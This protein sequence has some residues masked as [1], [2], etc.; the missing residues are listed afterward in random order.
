GNPIGNPV[1]LDGEGKGTL[2]VPPSESGKQLD[3]LVDGQLQ[4]TVEVPVLTTQPPVV[5][6]SPTVVDK[7]DPNTGELLVTGKPGGTA[8]LQ[9]KDGNPIGN[10]VVLDS[11]GKGTLVVPPSESGKP[12]DVLV[13]GQ[14]Q[15]TVE[16]PVLTTQPPVVVPSPVVVDKVDPNTGELLVTGKPGGTAQLQDKDGN[17]I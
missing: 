15:S 16:V 8:Q 7:V 11:E 1:V 3:V 14:L 10:P 17:P 9:D 13:D 2:V 12:L 5:V 4:S 6:P